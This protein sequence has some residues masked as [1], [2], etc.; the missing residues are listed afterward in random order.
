VEAA[1]GQL[2][3]ECGGNGAVQQQQQE[4]VQHEHFEISNNF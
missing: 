3:W 4:E 2:I 1:D